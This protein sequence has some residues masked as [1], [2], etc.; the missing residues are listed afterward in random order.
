MSW[1]PSEAKPTVSIVQTVEKYQASED[2][3]NTRF[4]TSVQLQQKLF[5]RAHYSQVGYITGEKVQPARIPSRK[6]IV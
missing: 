2:M 3:L 1:A 4:P 5:P 6:H